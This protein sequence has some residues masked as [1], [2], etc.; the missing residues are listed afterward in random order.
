MTIREP[1]AQVVDKIAN[2][3]A[4]ALVGMMTR[5][6]IREHARRH[7]TIPVIEARDRAISAFAGLLPMGD[8]K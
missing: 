1:Q 7:L 4:Q 8:R 3:D 6:C 2:L 5:Y